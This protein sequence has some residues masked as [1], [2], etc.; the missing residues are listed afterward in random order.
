MVAQ[1]GMQAQFEQILDHLRQ[2]V[3]G[4]VKLRVEW[5]DYFDETESKAAVLIWAE[6]DRPFDPAD[7]TDNRTSYWKVTTFPPQVCERFIIY[8]N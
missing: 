7:R 4:L 1:L 6:R 2:H 3:P 5:Q 8:V